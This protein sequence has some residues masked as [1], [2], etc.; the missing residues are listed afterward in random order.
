MSRSGKLARLV[1]IDAPDPADPPWRGETCAFEMESILKLYMD[2]PEG[3]P[4]RL[5]R[6][7]PPKNA[8]TWVQPDGHQPAGPPSLHS[9][10]P[11]R[12]PGLGRSLYRFHLAG[13][14][15]EQTGTGFALTRDTVGEPP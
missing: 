8:S 10:P 2:I 5:W 13:T 6:G 12:S 7:L 15:T 11:G 4:E 9:T 1:S 14:R 3:Q